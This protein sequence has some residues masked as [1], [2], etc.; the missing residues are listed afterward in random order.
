MNCDT[1]RGE[2]DQY[3][4]RPRKTRDG[5]NLESDR[6]SH[7]ALWY[8]SEGDAISYARWHSR[9]KGCTIAILDGTGT[10][11]RTEEFSPG[12]FAY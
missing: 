2:L 9:V 12:N 10:V 7:G 4:V 8:G 3:K 11:L 6:L 1:T 5:F